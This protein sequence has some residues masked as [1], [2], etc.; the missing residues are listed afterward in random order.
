MEIEFSPDVDAF[1]SKV[2]DLKNMELF[3]EPRV[4]ALLVKMLEATK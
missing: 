4:N 2:A 1:R 3:Q